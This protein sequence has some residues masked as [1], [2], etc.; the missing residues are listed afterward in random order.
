M[1]IFTTQFTRESGVKGREK[2]RDLK[3]LQMVCRYTMVTSRETDL[4]AKGFI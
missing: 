1:D 3:D 2:D 4:M